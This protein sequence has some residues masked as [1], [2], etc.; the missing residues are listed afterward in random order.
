MN[1]ERN[2]N[3]IPGITLE[4]GSY[5]YDMKRVKEEF[6][7]YFKNILCNMRGTFNDEQE[8]R[9]LIKYQVLLEVVERMIRDIEKD[10]TKS[11]LFSMA[12]TK[13]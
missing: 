5:S 8:L 13:C 3:S 7:K 9:R 12:I 10:E 6:V 1:D 11:T 2:R 4:D